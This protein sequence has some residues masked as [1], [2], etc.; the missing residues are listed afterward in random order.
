MDFEYSFGKFI[1]TGSLTPVKKTDIHHSGVE[2]IVPLKIRTLSL[3]ESFESKGIVS[4]KDLFDKPTK[5]DF[6]VISD[7]HLS[8]IAYLIYRRRGQFQFKWIKN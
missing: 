8:D 7:F 6:D 2:R 4:L 1:L 5:E 3:Y